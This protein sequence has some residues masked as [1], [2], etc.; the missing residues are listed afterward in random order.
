M[1]TIYATAT[2]RGKAGISVVRLSGPASHKAVAALCGALPTV[3]RA[4][5]RRLVWQDVL[6]DE[7]LVLLFAEGR[8]FTGEAMAEL[9]LHGSVAVVAAALRA[10]SDQPGLRLAEPGEF[11]RRALENGCL[12]LA[13]VEGLADLID[14]E[15]EAQRR[16]ALKVLSGA[17]GVLAA[18]WRSKVIR[19][20]ALLEATIDF[21]DEDV[22]VD[23]FPEVTGL[24][25]DL[26]GELHQEAAG[27]QIA[28]R[29]RD[30][31]EVAIV[32]APNV[33]KST[34][35]N[36]FAGREAAITSEIAGTTRDV[37]EVQMDLNGL[38]ITLLD[39]AG[40]QTTDDVVEKIGIERAIMRAASADLRIFLIV[41]NV[42]PD[43]IFPADGD[44]V[45]RAKADLAEV[46]PQELAVSGKTGAGVDL[47]LNAISAALSG[48]VQPSATLTRE[49]HRTAALRAIVDLEMVQVEIAAGP[50]RTELAAEHL[51]GAIRHL[52]SL[53]GRV[54]V[55]NLLD[56]IFSSF[57][58]GK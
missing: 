41:E 24:I 6:I 22:P 45:V 5:L 34:L 36:I 10:L 23:V 57:C 50:N 44:L 21:V 29:L 17:V 3:Q 37:I 52:E 28:E 40:L 38:P 49:R 46:Y 2:A 16:Q 32:G 31:F 14:A 18:N 26:I 12:D 35:L 51:R 7:A 13:Q 8:S 25:A 4:S 19:A 42:H 27:A 1:H 39:T 58:I 53:V 9:H 56:E 15:T 47:L 30:G 48:R 11:T 54:G 55:E 43:G 20:A 33:G